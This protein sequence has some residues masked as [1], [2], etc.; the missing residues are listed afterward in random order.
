MTACL[1]AVLETQSGTFY[2]MQAWLSRVWPGVG[3]S[4]LKAEEAAGSCPPVCPEGTSE[5][6]APGPQANCTQSFWVPTGVTDTGEEAP[7]DSAGGWLEAREGE[8]S[9]RTPQGLAECRSWQRLSL[10]GFQRGDIFHFQE[11]QVTLLKNF[12]ILLFASHLRNLHSEIQRSKNFPGLAIMFRSRIYFK[13]AFWGRCE[14]TLALL[15]SRLCPWGWWGSD[16]QGSRGSG[17]TG[18]P[19]VGGPCGGV[20]RETASNTTS[21]KGKRHQELQV[22]KVEGNGDQ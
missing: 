11:V 5:H 12:T 6:R 1:S 16:L 4:S 15:W 3:W 18:V 2:L 17:T 19:G 21:E 7:G 22:S 10:F 8:G 20:Y 13:L 9:T 14:V